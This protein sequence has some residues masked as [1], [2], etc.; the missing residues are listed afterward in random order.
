M[1]LP[2]VGID[3]LVVPVGMAGDAGLRLVRAL[4][5]ESR[6]AVIECRW[7]PRVQAVTRCAIARE[8][9]RGMG[10]AL[11]TVEIGGMTL[12]AIDVGKIVVAS[13]V[14]GDAGL[15]LMGALERESRL[16]MIECRWSPGVLPMAGCAIVR[17][18]VCRMARTLRG[19]EIAR[20]ALPAI[21]VRQIVIASDVAGGA[22]LGLVRA[23]QGKPRTAVIEGRG[24]PGKLRMARGT[25]VRK[26][27]GEV[28]RILYAVEIPLMALEALDV[29]E[30]VVARGVALR[31]LDGRMGAD[32][33]EVRPAMVEG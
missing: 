7:L 15:R 20:M 4:E 22:L 2:A 14:A 27:I 18:Q 29:G 23:G 24:S 16:T 10:W 12:P 13:R 31:T 11:R 8:L 32:E 28:V 9:I 3:K 19:I 6:G 21:D 26:L 17:K 33:R 25:V 1:A 5:R 30:L